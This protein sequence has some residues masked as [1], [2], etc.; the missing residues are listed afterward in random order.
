VWIP[1]IS[2]RWTHTGAQANATASAIRRHGADRGEQAREPVEHD[3][4]ER[5]D[6]DPR[7]EQREPLLPARDRGHPADEEKEGLKEDRSVG[8]PREFPLEQE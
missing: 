3:Q 1:V 5:H 8:Q 2:I 7:S 4:E 6:A